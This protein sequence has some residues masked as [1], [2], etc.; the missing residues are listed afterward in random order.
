MSVRVNRDCLL[1]GRG[2][3]LRLVRFLEILS[4]LKPRL[5]LDCCPRLL[6]CSCVTPFAS[7]VDFLVAKRLNKNNL[8]LSEDLEPMNIFP[9]LLMQSI[10][11]VTE[12]EERTEM[13]PK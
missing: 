3:L 13:S 1:E 9:E 7:L 10:D 2:L 4:F 6:C 12:S 5:V 11:V 8:S